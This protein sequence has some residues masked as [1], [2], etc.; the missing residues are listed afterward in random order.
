M[1]DIL[2]NRSAYV[3]IDPDGTALDISAYVASYG[4]DLSRQEVDTSTL[5]DLV[6]QVTKGTA[7]FMFNPNINWPATLS[8]LF[9]RMLT[10]FQSNTGTVIEWRIKGGA[11]SVDNPTFKGTVVITG[12]NMDANRN[13]VSAFQKNYPV[14]ALTYRTAGSGGFTTITPAA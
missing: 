14:N 11:E 5:A 9:P 10:E 8:A 4:M 13:Q 7:K 2:V 6:D 3:K 12:F 1:A